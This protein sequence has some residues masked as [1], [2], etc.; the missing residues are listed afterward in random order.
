MPSN[1][2]VAGECGDKLSVMKLNWMVNGSKENNTVT[3][4][5]EK[6]DSNYF[7]RSVNLSVYLDDHNF[8]NHRGKNS[9]IR[10]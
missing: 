2:S 5:F 7:I 1:A 10:I 9:K 6:D 8:P 3:V 4:N